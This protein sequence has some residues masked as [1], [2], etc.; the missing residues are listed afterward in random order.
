ML[1]TVFIIG[2]YELM[3][4]VSPALVDGIEDLSWL[5]FIYILSFSLAY[6]L[7][8]ATVQLRMVKRRRVVKRVFTTCCMTLLFIPFVAQFSDPDIH[9]PYMFFS[10]SI[11]PYMILLMLERLSI[12][13]FFMHI[14]AN[15]RNQKNVV[16]IG[17]G[18][19]VQKMYDILTTP[20]YGYDIKGVFYDG[21]CPHAQMAEK[22]IGG[23][24]DIQK[25][26]ATQPTIHEIYGYLPKE[27]HDT[28]DLL[29]KLCD[30]YLIRFYY[31]PAIDVFQGNISIKF[32]EDVP[33]IAYRQEPLRKTFNKQ[34][35]R[36]FDVVFSLLV[37]VLVFPW[38]W[39]WVAVMIR[40]QS[41]GPIFF[42][43]D[44]TGMD[45]KVFKCI[46]FRSMKV[47][48]EADKK[49]ATKDDPRKFPFGDFMRRTNIDELPQFIN[50]FKGDMSVVGPR[51]HM[52]KH[53]E[54]YSRLISNFMVRH[55]A[56]PGIT[57]LAQVSGFRGETHTIDQMEGRVEKDIEYIENWS[58]ILDIKIILKTILNMLGKEKGNAY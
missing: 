51:P 47:N 25:W 26:L 57:G 28:I 10:L 32:M 52:L 12:R 42:T 38:V 11:P 35:K 46:K 44:R 43:Q 16:L 7:F 22:H 45:G 15:Q 2:F 58:L 27:Q 6:L 54:E 19:V 40:K 36:A 31:L 53:T 5:L 17:N 39:L 8:P 29:S 37:L 49:Q 41:P 24:G 13:A 55:F 1:L 33:I 14:R 21:E 4:I 30:K 48:D 56:K 20:I 23:I 3:A 50:V 34:I 18:A 9:I